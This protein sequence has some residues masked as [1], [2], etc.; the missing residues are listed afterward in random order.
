M[1]AM[2]LRAFDVAAEPEGV[3]GDA[4]GNDAGHA[5]KLQRF[6][7]PAQHAER[8]DGLSHSTHASLLWPPRCMETTEP[9][10]SA[11]R[12]RPPGMATQPEPVLRT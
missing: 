11:T 5:P 9:S 4:A 6:V 8:V 1:R 12:T 10:A 7:G 2:I 3:V